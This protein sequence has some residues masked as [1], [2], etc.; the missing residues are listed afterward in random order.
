MNS[1]QNLSD[2]NGTIRNVRNRYKIVYKRSNTLFFVSMSNV[3]ILQHEPNNY[4]SY[5]RHTSLV[6]LVKISS[7]IVD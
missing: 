4:F 2:I 3:I 6:S 1:V 5:S 7:K